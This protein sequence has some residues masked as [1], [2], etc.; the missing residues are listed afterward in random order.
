MIRDHRTVLTGAGQVSKV[1]SPFRRAWEAQPLDP[2]QPAPRAL[3]PAAAVPSD[4]LPTTASLGVADD[5]PAGVVRGGETAA[6]RRLERFL[7]ERAEGYGGNRDLLG[8]DATSRLSADLHYGCVSPRAAYAA[9]DRRLPGHDAFAQELIW[10]DF[11]GHVMAEWPESATTEFNPDLRGLPWRREGEHLRAWQEGRTGYP[12][13]DAG[14][15]QL[16]TQGWM[17]NRA[18]MITASFLCKDLLVDWRLGVA[19]FLRHLIDG[20]VAS[21]TGGWQWAAGTGTDAQPFFR[22]FNPVT[23]GEKFDPEGVYV[24][25][26]VPEL[27]AVPSK[28]IHHPWDMP[29]AVAARAGVVIGKDYPAPIVD[30]QEARRAALAFFEGR[31]G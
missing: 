28:W 9:L 1:Y 3:T 19:H 27:W 22:I 20:D 24:R 26:F 8:E 15:R 4:P 10:R 29:A 30:H 11:Y 23:Q 6:G 21:N 14:L 5:V 25:R 12:V 7:A 2:P 18:R 16:V 13:V 17:H 31:G